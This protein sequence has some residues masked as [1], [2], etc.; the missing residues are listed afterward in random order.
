MSG[1]PIEPAV[2]MGLAAGDEI[3]AVEGLAAEILSFFRLVP[4]GMAGLD[5][6]AVPGLIA[7]YG[8]ADEDFVLNAVRELATAERFGSDV[9]HKEREIS[10]AGR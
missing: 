8:I 9:G 1:E 7:E 4:H 3:P 5:Y 6:S 10:R 2:A